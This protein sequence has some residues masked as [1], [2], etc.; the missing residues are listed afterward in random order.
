[1]KKTI[2]DAE[3][4]TLFVEELDLVNAEEFEICRTLAQRLKAPIEQVVAE[5]GRVPLRFVLEQI[6]GSW[7]VQFTDL[8][9]AGIDTGALRR[10]REEVARAHHV[11]A[12]AVGPE[13]LSVA[14]SDPRDR[15][16]LNE[17]RR[18]T[19][20]KIIPFFAEPAAINR[21]HLLYHEHVRGMLRPAAAET[22]IAK[23]EEVS[24]T[25]L[26]ARTLEFATVSGAS[27]IHIEPY[28]DELVVRVRVDGVLRD[29]LSR[30]TAAAA[31]LA[32]R[33]KAL[34]GMRI[35]DRRSPQD[36]RFM[37]K[38]GGVQL[39]LRVSSLPTQHGEKVVMRVIPQDARVFDL[40]ALGLH[41]D[42]HAALTRT[43]A[44]PFGMVLV[45]GPTG[46][47]KSTSLYAMI[48]R[49]TAERQSLVNISTIED[50][51]EH[52]LPRVTQ[53]SV[54]PTAGIDFASGLRALLRQDPDVIM[55]GE[56]RDRE[57]AE[58]AVRA[59]L[60]GRL[61]IASLHTNDT[62]SA[63]P[64]LIDMGIEP[65]LLSST[66][67]M[68]IAQR[69]VRKICTGCRESVTLDDASSALLLDRPDWDR[70]SASLQERGILRSGADAL[71][72]MR[73]FRGRGCPTCNG[74]GFRGRTGLFEVLEITD[75]MRRLILT[76]PDANTL[77]AA[78]MRNGMRTMFEDGM[79]KVL[80][81]ETT[82]EEL[83]RVAA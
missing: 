26:L 15:N 28:A 67:T 13:G 38:I 34:A 19:N 70:I 83:V 31:P 32:A 25:D 4:R 40:E 55:V 21:A 50:P 17:L 33:I 6:A 53:V 57:T 37:H 42:D 75:E 72:G 12:F 10:I 5:R 24:A 45:T 69:L 64:R 80:L 2:N 60:V 58:T 11:A 73:L 81:G 68:V 47:G 82:L 1:V 18:L 63:V 3:A 9:T 74:S 59:A 41:D 49:L 66:V 29:V 62:V 27:D 22:G 36:G 65:F 52:E 71:A 79:V 48:S 51:V 78:G 35:D 56:I 43:L 7:G 76:R 20:L 14:M 46:S 16:A 23:T 8:K 77:A 61:L 39:D 44:R 30:P 54:N